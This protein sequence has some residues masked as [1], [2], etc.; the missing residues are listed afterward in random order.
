MLYLAVDS[1]MRPQEY[2][3]AARK[4]LNEQGLTGD[5]HWNVS[6]KYR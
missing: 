2:I 6:G 5:R 1:G 3:V 4:N